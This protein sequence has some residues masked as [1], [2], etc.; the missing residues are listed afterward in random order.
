MGSGY[1]KV[2]FFFFPSYRRVM[3]GK[4]WVVVANVSKIDVRFRPPVQDS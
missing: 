2:F 4:G 1:R 3:R